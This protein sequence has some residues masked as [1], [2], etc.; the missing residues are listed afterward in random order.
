MDLRRIR[1]F[2]A[3]A[4]EGS[5]TRAA[6]RLHIS[7]PPLSQNV[8]ALEVEMGVQLLVRDHQ[9]VVPTDAGRVFLRQARHI[10]GTVS[11]AVDETV[12]VAAGKSG[13]IRIG[14]VT[15][16]LFRLLPPVLEG[17]RKRMPDADIA[18]SENSSQGQFLALQRGD[19]D[20]AIVHGPMH[21]EG[22]HVERL[23]TERMC[24]VLPAGHRLA[25]G[26]PMQVKALAAEDFVL[27]I[28]DLA[29]AFFDN[30][31][32]LCVRSGFSPRIRH[33]VRDSPTMVKLVGLGLGVTIVS[34]ALA[35]LYTGSTCF[36][37]FTDPTATIEYCIVWKPERAS[38]LVEQALA[39]TREV[40]AAGKRPRRSAAG[41][42]AP[43]K[44]MQ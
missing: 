3:V 30:L 41:S 34:E 25:A 13:S 28:R 24:A 11:A 18:I 19:I 35:S 44:G 7:Q 14:V 8:K 15:S 29:P 16:S 17:L 20:F 22:L 9:G 43:T 37:H 5:F 10:L 1:Y 39:V 27:G 21:A 6:K 32:S 4:E 2:I 23:C 33:T 26:G 31:V 38:G 42:R 12:R 40:A 36:R